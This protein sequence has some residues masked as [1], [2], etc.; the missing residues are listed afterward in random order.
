MRKMVSIILTLALLL[1]IAVI[2][3]YAVETSADTIQIHQE[4]NTQVVTI[5]GEEN[6]RHYQEALGE[7]YDPNLL[8]IQR[9]IDVSEP[10]ITAIPNGELD[11]NTII[12]ELEIRS[13][14]VTTYTDF[15]HLLRQYN[16]PSGKVL[17]DE[18]VSISTTYSADAGISADF[19]EAKLGF[20]VQETNTFRIEWEEEYEF[21]VKIKVYPIYEKTTGQVWDDDVWYDDLIGYFTV[22][23]ALGDDVRVYRA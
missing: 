11:P 1:S 6:I 19:L 21:A 15:T 8:V 20:A 5:I 4:G 23:R 7:E 16:R 14:S 22:Y 9:R 3:A 13:K 12:R 10:T 2:P 17:I 18:G